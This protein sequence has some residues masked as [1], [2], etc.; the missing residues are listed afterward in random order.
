MGKKWLS[1]S[2][3]DIS[4][5]LGSYWRQPI[6]I[7]NC[8]DISIQLLKY[9]TNSHNIM[10]ANTCLMVS[11]PKRRMRVLKIENRTRIL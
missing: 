6:R 2:N 4:F 1:N 5:Y 9:Y 7:S 3:K 8:I 11:D 10:D